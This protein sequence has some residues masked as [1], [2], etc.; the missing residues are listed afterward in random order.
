V[1]AKRLIA[2]YGDRRT[3]MKLCPVWFCPGGSAAYGVS[4]IQLL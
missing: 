4:Q 2:A 3:L 1:L